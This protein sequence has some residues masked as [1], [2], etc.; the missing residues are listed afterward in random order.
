MRAYPYGGYA[1]RVLQVD[2]ARGKTV[3][4]KLDEGLAKNYI[5]GNGFCARLLFNLIRPGTDPLGP[6]NVLI[7]AAGPLNG[8]LWPQTGRYEVAAKSPLTGIYGEA[9]SGGHWGAELKHAGFDAIVVRGRAAKP[10]YLS[11][12]NGRAEL[13]PAKRL[14][15]RTT[16]ETEAALKEEHGGDAHVVSIGRAGENLVRFAC[17]VTD[18]HRAAARTGMGAVMGS[19]RLKAVVARGSLGLEVAYPDR[20]AGLAEAAYQRLLLHR[21]S[22]NTTKYGTSLLVEAMSEIGRFPTHNFQSGVFERAAEI[23]GERIVT[24]YKLK[25]RACFACPLRCKNYTRVEA[26]AFACFGEGPEYETLSSLGGRCGNSDLESII[27][28]NSLC[29]RYGLDTI[30]CGGVIAF[31]M[32]CFERGLLGPRQTGGLELHWGDPEVIIALIHAIAEREGF[33]AK[34]AEGTAKFARSLGREAMRYAMVVKGLDEPAQDGRAQKS[35]GLSHATA[36]RGADHLTSFEVLSEVGFAEE[37][38]KRFGKRVMPEAADRLNPKYKP[39]M[40]RDGENFCAIVDSLV[41]CKFG[42]V[43]PPAFYFAEFAAALT[44]TTG[45]HYTERALRLIGERIFT[46]ERAFD[47]REGVTARDDTIPERLTKEPAPAGPCKGHVVELDRMLREYYKLRG[48]D[49]K[50]GSVP[51]KRLGE[52]GLEN[53]A[54]ELAAMRKLPK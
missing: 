8:T 22:A 7:F 19:K 33:G 35:M 1:G 25:D 10:V 52:L 9:N 28:A 41:A 6:S 26:G 37:I 36:N 23:G 32:E 47:I 11:V 39:L 45:I 51:R 54:R 16:H 48:W 50:T 40:V 15:G 49:P 29:N 5:G 46:L 53:I 21:F 13:K 18:L 4:E 3:A 34:L 2:L 43:W 42:A 44:A 17:I 27:H 24:R 31:A 20:L 38:E 14:W 12:E 30:S